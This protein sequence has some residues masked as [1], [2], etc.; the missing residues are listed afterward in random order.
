MKLICLWNSECNV[1]YPAKTN[2][3]RI[4]WIPDDLHI[5]LLN[6]VDALI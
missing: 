6:S 5:Q 3:D 4:L 1:L 2:S